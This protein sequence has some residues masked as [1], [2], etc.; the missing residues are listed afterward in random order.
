MFSPQLLHPSLHLQVRLH[1]QRRQ[2][3]QMRPHSTKWQTFWMRSHTSQSLDVTMLMSMFLLDLL[4]E[5]PTSLSVIVPEFKEQRVEWLSFLLITRYLL[6]KLFE[7]TVITTAQA[8]ILSH[9]FLKV[10][11]V[12]RVH[13]HPSAQAVCHG[14]IQFQT[15]TSKVKTWHP[16]MT[17]VMVLK[18]LLRFL[19]AII[20]S[21]CTTS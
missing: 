9:T 16:H 3:Q 5:L 21:T 4:T 2:H 6:P 1:L 8:V 7:Y 11:L 10:D 15:V 14:P 12:Q 17:L 20:L 19:L 18:S 13:G